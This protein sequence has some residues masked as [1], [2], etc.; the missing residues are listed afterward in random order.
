M[1][2][3]GVQKQTG[4]KKLESMAAA[5]NADTFNSSVQCLSDVHP[6]YLWK[7]SKK[8]T[9]VALSDALLSRVMTKGK[10]SMISGI[11]YLT[12]FA[13]SD[14]VRCQLRY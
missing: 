5:L 11:C 14:K 1:S 10:K 6:G 4:R 2:A 9:A 13:S 8:N 12:G 7:W 3:H